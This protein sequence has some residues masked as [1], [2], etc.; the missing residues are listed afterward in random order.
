MFVEEIATGVSKLSEGQPCRRPYV[1]I[2]G[3]LHGNES[4]GYAALRQ[5][6]G[7]LERG[8]LTLEQGTLF[9]IQGNPEATA[10][11]LRCTAT[12]YDLNRLWDFAYVDRLQ[13]S[14]WG[15]EHHRA[16]EL[17]PILEDLDLFL[18][19]HS[20]SAPTPAFAVTNGV[21]AA[22]EIAERLDVPFVI[23]SWSDLADR[24]IIGF[25]GTK[26][27]PSLSVECGSHDDPQT[28]AEAYRIAR[29]FLR[30]AAVLGGDWEAT[31][32]GARSVRVVETISKPSPE[33]RFATSLSGFQRLEPGTLL[34]RDRVTEIRVSEGC[35][36]VLPNEEVEVG[37]D[38]VYLAVDV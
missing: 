19:L 10:H 11:G 4:A 18:D 21:P 9:L 24:V 26:G 7:Q 32:N 8:D 31:R 2:C 1:G 25:L 5:L 35:Y 20:A 6:G 17:K 27:V 28:A 13:M 12:G 37:E 34:G 29:N 30:A 3:A 36:A 14:A 33:F 22:E 15:Y 16:C 38:V 23:R